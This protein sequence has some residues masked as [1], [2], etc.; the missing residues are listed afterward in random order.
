MSN[1]HVHAPVPRRH[2]IVK[3]VSLANLLDSDNVA[4]HRELNAMMAHAYSKVAL[5]VAAECL[6]SA[7]VWP[8]GKPL[9]DGLGLGVQMNGQTFKLP[10][11]IAD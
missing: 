6:G 1:G 5:K 2:S 9:D 11:G 7:H 4:I 8:L 3:F 10:L